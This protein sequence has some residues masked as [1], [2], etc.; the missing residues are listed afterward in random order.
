MELGYNGVYNSLSSGKIDVQPSYTVNMEILHTNAF[1]KIGYLF[2]NDDFKSLAL[3]L[4]ANLNDQ[5]TTIGLTNYKGRQLSGY[6]NLIYQQELGKKEENYFKLGASCQVDSVTE[7]LRLRYL[8]LLNN[9]ANFYNRRLEIV[10]GV[11]GEFT[12]QLRK[13]G[14]DSWY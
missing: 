10:P 12:P 14:V 7:T 13:M 2:P 3:Q 1:A 4:S 5:E 8:M 11:Y 9:N 6:A